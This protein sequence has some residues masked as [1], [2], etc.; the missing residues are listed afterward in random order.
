MKKIFLIFSMALLISCN[1]NIETIKGDL[2]FKLVNVTS[3]KGMS[4]QEIEQLKK[5]LNKL[6]NDTITDLKEKELL[7][8]F[9]KLEKQQLLGLP[10]IV[11]KLSNGETKQIILSKKE[12]EKIKSFT[13]DYLQT[14]HKKVTLELELKPRDSIFYSDNI[15]S[16]EESKGHTF[17]TK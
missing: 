14:N 15:L 11:I 12:Y 1:S 7:T 16:I 5:T 17:Y 4:E 6:K 2:Y 8:Y 3:P 9:E 13:L 10:Y